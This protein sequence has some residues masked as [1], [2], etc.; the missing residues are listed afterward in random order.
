M[1]SDLKNSKMRTCFRPFWTTLIFWQEVPGWDLVIAL[2][3][4][5]RHYKKEVPK[6][7]SPHQDFPELTRP[8][9]CHQYF[10]ITISSTRYTPV[11]NWSN[12][13]LLSGGDS[14]FS[15]VFYSCTGPKGESLHCRR[16]VYSCERTQ[17]SSFSCKVYW[18]NDTGSWNGVTAIQWN[19]THKSRHCI[20]DTHAIAMHTVT[21]NTQ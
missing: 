7:D 6:R 1:S 20:V 18:E 3:R 16:G 2:K 15:W 19:A 14:S 11:S 5:F 9:F 17:T 10:L 4:L 13:P 8:A 21:I 12:R